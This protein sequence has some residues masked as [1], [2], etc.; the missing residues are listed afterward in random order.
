MGSKQRDDLE[1]GESSRVGEPLQDGGD[2]VLR[3]GN[4]AHDGGDGLVGASGHEFELR[5]TLFQGIEPCTSSEGVQI[6]TYR[7]VAKSNS[8]SELNN[9]ASADGVVLL[10][11]R[12]QV[13]DAVVDTVVRLKIR[14]NGREEE[15]RAIGSPTTSFQIGSVIDFEMMGKG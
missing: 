6:S 8:T 3:L 13:V 9:I 10:H 2:T 1:R 11:E 5:S 7:A 15:H 4:Q 14:L 12:N